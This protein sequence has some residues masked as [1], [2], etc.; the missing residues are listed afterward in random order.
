L[1]GTTLNFFESRNGGTLTLHDQTDG[2]TAN[3]HL[4][5]GNYTNSSFA[6]APDHGTGTMVK[7]V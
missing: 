2:L 3:I 1:S 7:F 4:T 5:G 6:L